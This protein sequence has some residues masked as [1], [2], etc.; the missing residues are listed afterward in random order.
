MKKNIELDILSD[1]HT[2][3]RYSDGKN[4]LSEMADAAIEKGLKTI[5][6]TDHMPLFF[7]DRYAMAY[8]AIP[9]YRDDILKAKD[10]YKGKLTILM[11]MEMEYLS[12]NPKWTEDIVNMGWDWL[13]ASVHVVPGNGRYYL[14][15]G[16]DAEFKDALYNGFSGEIKKLVTTYYETLAQTV[17]SGLFHVV[18]HLDVIK[19]HNTDGKLFP[20]HSDWHRALVED[21]LSIIQKTG[22]KVEINT[23]GIDQAG[24][25]E[26]YPSNWILDKC[27][28][29]DIPIV[30]SSDAHSTHVLGN[31]FAA[32]KTYPCLTD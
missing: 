6:V 20:E 16:N 17:S 19:R 5:A 30:L 25:R 21:I 18:G 8:K 32:F 24:T 7:E 31:H 26:Q 2:H 4:T 11:G 10:A 15:N 9:E 1:L 29:K 28:E 14:V 23:K 13:I 12:E 27:L 3:T 22:L